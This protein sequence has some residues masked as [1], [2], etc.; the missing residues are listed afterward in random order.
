MTDLCV[1]FW[2]NFIPCRV[3]SSC[4]FRAAIYYL[5]LA[6][7]SR[8]AVCNIEVVE[9]G[10]LSFTKDKHAVMSFMPFS[11]LQLPSRL[12]MKMKVWPRRRTCF[13]ESRSDF[14]LKRNGNR[15]RNPPNSNG[16]RDWPFRRAEG[17]CPLSGQVAGVSRSGHASS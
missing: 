10:F 4:P 1:V 2:A 11:G 8:S 15:R 13:E 7:A 16:V 9:K 17:A 3:S 12:K 5:S 14:S 6:S